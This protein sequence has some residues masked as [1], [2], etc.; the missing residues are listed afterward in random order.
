MPGANAA[1]E[2]QFQALIET[3]LDIVVVLNYDGTFRYL[4]PSVQRTTG[5]TPETLIGENAFSYMHPDDAREQSEV[6]GVIVSDPQLA[7]LGA[8]RS[9]RFRHKDGHWVVLEAVSTKLPEGPEPPGVVVNARDVTER[10]QAQEAMRETAESDRRLA[11]EN[12]ILAEVGRI[13][14]STL[15]IEE[16]FELF[17]VEVSRLIEFDMIAASIVDHVRQTTTF[18]YWSGPAEYR[19]RFQTTVPLEGSVTGKVVASGE[20]VLVHGSSHEDFRRTFA[21]LSESRKGGVLSWLGLPLANRGVTIG[22]LLFFSSKQ[23]AFSDLD[24]ALAGRVSYQIAGA[25]DNAQLFDGLN[26]A[27]TALADVIDRNRM[28]LETAH[29]AFI[30]IDDR[31]QVIA[32]NSQAESTFGWT[33][34]EA[35][36]QRIA[37]LIIPNRLAAK[38]LAG[39]KN[40]VTT[41]KKRLSKGHTE[42]VAKNRDGHEFPV[43]LTV[44]P[45]K[46][47]DRYYFYAFIRD[48]TDRKEA[49]DALLRSEERFRAVYNNAANGIG[50]RA[51]DGTPKDLN[52]AFLNM[53]GY[54]MDE[55]RELGPGVLYDIKYEE[56]ERRLFERA[57][58]GEDIPPYEKEYIRKDGTRVI[59]EVR[60]SLERD[61]DGAP[62]GIV[63]VVSDITERQ[64]LEDEI[65]QYTKSLESAYGELQQ[66]DRL[67]DEFISTV[68]HELRT[69]LTSIKGSAEI[70]LT[71]DN[72]DRETQME[73][74]R[75]INKECDRLTRMVT[76]VLDL[77][78]MESREMNW[79]WGD[80]DLPEV[81]S[82]AVDG[83]QS[84]LLQK[85]L[86]IE[87]ELDSPLPVIWNDR[88]R[89]VQVVTNLLSNSIKF[90]RRGGNIWIRAKRSSDVESDGLGERLEVCVSDTGVGIPESEHENIFKK[91]KQVSETLTDKPT[92]SGLGLPIC[93]QIVEYVGGRMWVESTPGRGSSFYFTV[94]VAAKEQ[95]RR[96]QPEFNG[97]SAD[98]A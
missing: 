78:R 7:T 25:I 36:R 29:D 43:E 9:F 5:Y 2:S 87:V 86:S 90:T 70:L 98:T 14:G 65:A 85:D 4:S 76:E 95:E 45:L 27:E 74:L 40:F 16:V 77:S 50:T 59:T 41:G 19:D 46:L 60:A 42:L 63:A 67:K 75:I 91:F 62:I 97:F 38:H 66:L 52:P 73:F 6:F 57:L 1:G 71:Y 88:D 56:I 55:I 69:P 34:G 33:A 21:H 26:N 83:T 54:T 49:E 30:G 80:V 94:P 61:D 20:P 15:N 18:R 32:W 31:G 37:D 79:N 68:S 82:A 47:G 93:R 24:I 10:A 35:M 12:E 23:N 58:N 96:P 48:I 8:P 44:S 28:I 39:F 17:A 13:I 11:Q 51:I 64:L 72:E 22:A 89:L 92:G 3:A 84:L 81:V 53:V